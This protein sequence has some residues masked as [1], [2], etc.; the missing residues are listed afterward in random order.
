MPAFAANLRARGP[1]LAGRT[2]ISTGERAWSRYASKVHSSATVCILHA[3]CSF[4]GTLGIL[5]WVV[6]YSYLVRMVCRSSG[7]ALQVKYCISLR[8]NVAHWQ[9]L[10]VTV[11]TSRRRV[12][13][14]LTFAR[15]RDY[16]SRVSPH[17][18]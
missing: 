16:A 2:S 13:Q 18:G 1:T 17:L 8:A 12:S 5:R 15:C 4:S 14:Y 6:N 3:L 10:A 7:A 9:S 11:A